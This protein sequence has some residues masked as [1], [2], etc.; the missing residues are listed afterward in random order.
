MG[1]GPFELISD[2]C[3][4]ALLPIILVAR[5]IRA[6]KV[7]EISERL[8]ILCYSR[9]HFSG[10]TLYITTVRDALQVVT[11]KLVYIVVL[12]TSNTPYVA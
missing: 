9:G 4:E 12:T 2:Q 7:S 8:L 6:S 5:F 1:P 3:H 10:C 11:S